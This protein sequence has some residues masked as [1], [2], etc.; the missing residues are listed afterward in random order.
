MVFI[1]TKELQEAIIS[2][3]FNLSNHSFYFLM[4][5]IKTFY[6]LRIQV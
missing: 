6:H 5:V 4:S 2:Q 1:H 3:I